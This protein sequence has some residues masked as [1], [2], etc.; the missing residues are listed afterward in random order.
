MTNPIRFPLW[1]TLLTAL[2]FVSNLF[3]FG[4]ATMLFPNLTFP[5]AGESAVFPIQFF[6]VRHI[7]FAFPLL[8][9][10]VQRDVKVLT[11]LYSIFIIMSVLDLSLLGIYDYPIPIL[12]L[13]PFIEQLNT[14]GKV[15]VGMAAFLL[16]ISLGLNHLR[17]YQN[18]K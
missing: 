10:L 11:V 15:V 9:G 4:L 1:F 13:I 5:D 3:I 12:A 14:L 17:G 6:A 16:P 7:A 2:L 18:Q 8:Y